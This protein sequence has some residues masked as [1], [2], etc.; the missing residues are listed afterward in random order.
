MQREYRGK[1]K[2]TGEWVY[3]YL[4]K[5]WEQTYI[6][7]GT[8]NGIPDMI[9][10][11]SETVGQYTGLK[12]GKHADGKEMC[13]GDICKD[14]KGDIVTIEWN[15]ENF[16]FSCKIIKGGTLTKGL[17][18]PLWQYNDCKLNGYRYLTIIGNVWDN[19]ELLQEAQ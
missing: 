15:N 1:R 16:C 12:D 4:F 2:D 17:R 5:I 8:T 6:L 7:W 3:G 14:D 13:Q 10:V 11:I 19:P 9:E 18:F